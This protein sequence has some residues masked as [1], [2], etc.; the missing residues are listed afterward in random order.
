LRPGQRVD[1]H[2]GDEHAEGTLPVSYP[3]LVDDI[4]PGECILLADGSIELEVV[5]RATDRLIAQVVIGGR[6][7]SHKGVNFPSSRLSAP[8][9]TAKDRQDLEV[10]L[11]AGVDVVALSFVRHEEDLAPIREILARS[12]VPPLLVAK[13]EKPQAVERVCAIIDR[14][15]GL[16]VARGDLGVEMAVEEVPLV[17][18]RVIREARLAGRPVITATQMLSSMV[19]SPRPTRAEATD[20]ANAVLDGTDALMLSEET[21][22][23]SYPVE[24]VRT[25]DRIARRVEAQI[26][27]A[28]A[29]RESPPAMI[30][31]PTAAAISRA[32]CILADDL[33]A[34]AIVA[35]TMSGGTARL[36]SRLQPRMPI[37]GMTASVE[38][39]RQ[40]GLSWGVVTAR[41]EGLATIDDACAA[42]RAWCRDHGLAD[43]GDAIVVTA[44]LPLNEPGTTNVVRVIEA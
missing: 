17:Q 22:V 14:A 4:G 19:D 25:L 3:H 16:M 32:A 2:P 10:G 28:P 43:S 39:E 7:T 24:A 26:D 13:I 23:G 36:V 6:V 34:A 8:A 20:V 11:A 33:D 1:L 31:D 21:A 18:K 29:L 37:V 15:D 5:E 9:M 30:P 12:E 41:V 35:S 44:G 38:V 27:S 42:A 40:L